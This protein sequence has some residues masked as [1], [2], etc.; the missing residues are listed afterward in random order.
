LQ[1]YFTNLS[2]QKNTGDAFTSAGQLTPLQVFIS[3]L[4]ST[5]FLIWRLQFYFKAITR[6]LKLSKRIIHFS[7]LRCQKPIRAIDQIAS[8]NKTSSEFFCGAADILTD[9]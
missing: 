3:K 5:K 4:L 6:A 7:P 8:A 9:L 1:K 2:K